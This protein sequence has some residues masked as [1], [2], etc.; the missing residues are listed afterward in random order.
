[1]DTAG[2]TIAV[3][4]V[5]VALR[6]LIA[7]QIPG[8]RRSCRWRPWIAAAQ[9]GPIAANQRFFSYHLFPCRFEFPLIYTALSHQ[10]RRD[11][12]L[13]DTGPTP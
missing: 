13:W 1:M 3:G 2:R 6:F 8:T 10:A 5:F 9:S 12:L 7:Q 11:Y 4:L